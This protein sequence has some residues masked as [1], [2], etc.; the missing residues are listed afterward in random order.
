MENLHL[1]QVIHQVIQHQVSI[2]PIAKTT[3]IFFWIVNLKPSYIL[4]IIKIVAV[5]RVLYLW[6]S[7]GVNEKVILVEY[8]ASSSCEISPVLPLC[9]L[10]MIL[11][12]IVASLQ[13]SR[14][15]TVLG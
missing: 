8:V 6:S 9:D 3:A 4:R 5:N 7:S 15:K 2:L 1:K 10:S 11:S 13:G 14:P 12:V